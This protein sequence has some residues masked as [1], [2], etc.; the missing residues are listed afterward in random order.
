M[1]RKSLPL[2]GVRVLAAINGI[3]LFGHERGNIEVFKTLRDSGARVRVAISALDGGGDVGAELRRLDFDTVE[4]PFG[5]HWSLRR[6]VREPDLFLRN[7]RALRACSALFER[8]IANYRPT[9]LHL[10]TAFAYSYLAPALRRAALPVVFRLGDC[11]PLGSPVNMMLWRALARRADSIVANSNFVREMAIAGGAR[12]DRVLLIYNL[13]PAAALEAAPPC[14]RQAESEHAA[15]LLYVGSV[16]QHKG[17]F[18]LVEAVAQLKS[19]F[20]QITLDVLGESRWDGAFRNE[21]VQRIAALGLGETVVFHG[22]VRDPGPA[23]RRATLHVVPSLCP[24]SCAN[25][26]L[27]AK[28]EGVP[29]VV[30]P[31]GGLPELVRDGVDGVVCPESTAGSL[32]TGIRALL[33]DHAA[34][35]AMRAAALHDFAVRF[36]PQ[37]FARQWAEIY[38]GARGG[39]VASPANLS[40]RSVET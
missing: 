20:P 35:Q 29:S 1:T 4:L 34:R 28:R 16:A 24:E 18:P 31:S 23:Y 17:L 38:L 13:A 19:A 7:F 12:S 2:H 14:E 37:R 32:A 22:H 33:T 3:E 30:F 10:G 8:E 40:V 27:E 26:V 36:G 39:R 21:L 25:V 6:V 9:H 15:R 5:T 11:P